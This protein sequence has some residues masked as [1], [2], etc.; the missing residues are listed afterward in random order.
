MFGKKQHTAASMCKQ[1]KV[2]YGDEDDHTHDKRHLIFNG[3][4]DGKPEL[5]N[6]IAE[7]AHS[8]WSEKVVQKFKSK[9]TR[10]R[11]FNPHHH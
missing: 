6:K 10:T 11:E 5:L 1:M 9:G 8:N 2:R 3:H 4:G 7:E